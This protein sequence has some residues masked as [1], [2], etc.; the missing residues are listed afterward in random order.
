M[1][2]INFNE[3]QNAIKNLEKNLR[4]QKAVRNIKEGKFKRDADSVDYQ[5][6]I[7]YT[8]E[9]RN[10]TYNP[11]V[12]NLIFSFPTLKESFFRVFGYKGNLDFT[13]YPKCWLRDL[14]L[15]NIG[16]HCYLA[17]GILLGTNQVS[18][19][20]EWIVTG[21]IS[22]GDFTIFDQGCSVGYSTSIGKN[23]SIGF[24]VAIGIKNK[25]GNEVRIGGRSNIAHGCKIG[26]EVII[27]DNCR[28]G[29]FSVIEDG[30][31]LAPYTD[32]PPFCRVTTEGI[33]SRR[34]MA[35]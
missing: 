14:P 8:R 3:V 33:F 34:R 10:F 15:L 7:T 27:A 19:D 22:I 23:C 32:I 31:E 26:N 12:L 24:E 17:D 18:P 6:R 5:D 13:L 16:K 2:F 20:Q 29:S 21:P 25:I 35:A 4:F 30:V 9:L 1:S 28:I 11:A